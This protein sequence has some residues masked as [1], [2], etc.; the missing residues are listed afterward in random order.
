MLL[1]D[2]TVHLSPYKEKKESSL[3][4]QMWDSHPHPGCTLQ[5]ALPEKLGVSAYAVGGQV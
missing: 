3:G 5:G 2:H 4:A 1:T